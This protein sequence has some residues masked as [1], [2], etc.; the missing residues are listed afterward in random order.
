[1]TRDRVMTGPA[2]V[3]S[4]DVE[5]APSIQ[6]LADAYRAWVRDGVTICRMVYAWKENGG[7]ERDLDDPENWDR[8]LAAVFGLVPSSIRGMVGQGRTYCALLEFQQ[9]E[10]LQDVRQSHLAA[11]APLRHDVE[12]LEEAWTAASEVVATQDLKRLTASQLTEAV[13]VIRVREGMTRTDVTVNRVPCE[14]CHGKG[15]TYGSIGDPGVGPGT[16]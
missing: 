6:Q 10:Q 2:Y 12:L 13:Q 1:M 15:W 9:M 3:P 14:V 5:L 4:L 11:L 8:Y 7:P 16:T